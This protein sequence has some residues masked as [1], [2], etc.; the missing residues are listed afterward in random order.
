MRILG[1]LFTITAVTGCITNDF[2]SNMAVGFVPTEPESCSDKLSGNGQARHSELNSDEIHLVNWNIQK[3]GDPDWTTDL[4]TIADEPDLMVFQ[5][6]AVN[7]NVWETVGDEHYQS[8]APGFR[9]FRSLTGV[10]TLSSAQPLTQCNLVSHEPWLGSPK[11]T[12]ITEYGLTETDSTLLVV[13]IHVINFTFGTRDFEKQ[14]RRALQSINEHEG[15]VLLSGDFNTWHLR[16]M[17]LME[18]LLS[19]RGFEAL[20]FAEDHRKKAFGKPLDHIYVRGLE[21]IEATTNR[22]VTSDH[23]P[24]SVRLRFDNGTRVSSQRIISAGGS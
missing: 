5:E 14:I 11:A 7:S 22:V 6:A 19:T 10:M 20:D 16:R 3:G 1:I 4:E 13:N 15:P 8:F 24:M 23:N 2:S 17:E 12:V 21:A 9:T 18:E